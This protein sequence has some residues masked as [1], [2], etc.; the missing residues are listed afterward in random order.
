MC[1]CGGGKI[2]GL[3]WGGEGGAFAAIRRPFMPVQQAWDPEL[4]IFPSLE[5]RA[6]GTNATEYKNTK[7]LPFS[8]LL[9]WL[10]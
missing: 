4:C 8:W 6:R 2:N 7:F 5:M 10:L 1:V 9:Q 3:G